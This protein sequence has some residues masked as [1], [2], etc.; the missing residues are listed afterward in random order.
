MGEVEK[1]MAGM[2]GGFRPDDEHQQE[3]TPTPNVSHGIQVFI[4][5]AAD[6]GSATSQG[7]HTHSRPS[8]GQERVQTTGILTPTLEPLLTR[9]LA[10][11]LPG[12]GPRRPRADP[13]RSC[14]LGPRFLARPG[15]GP[16]P[17]PGRGAAARPLRHLPGPRRPPPA[18]SPAGPAPG[19]PPQPLITDR[20][21]RPSSRRLPAAVA[22]AASAPRPGSLPLVQCAAAARPPS[23]SA[24]PRLRLRPR[25]E[26]GT[27]RGRRPRGCN[28]PA[29]PRAA[30]REPRVSLASVGGPAPGAA[31][32]D[33]FA[34]TCTRPLLAVW[35]TSGVS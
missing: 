7:T 34:L 30:P 5:V 28:A 21:L 32:A 1:H 35:V 25:E 10:F 18:L 8:K 20:T 19:A 6:V 13:P 16:P 17:G 24:T 3:D 31:L 15:W 9:K 33:R 27:A 14:H 26:A 11:T 22:A 12:P 23:P 4:P 29:P 2:D